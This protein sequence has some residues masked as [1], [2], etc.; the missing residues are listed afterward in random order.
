[1]LL[2]VRSAAADSWTDNWTVNGIPIRQFKKTSGRD[3]AVFSAGVLS[4]W[5]VHWLSHVSYLEMENLEWYQEGYREEVTTIMTDEQRRW[6]GRSG[7]VGQLIIGGVLKLTGMD[8]G[9]F[10]TGYHIGSFLHVS[11]YPMIHPLDRYRGG[12]MGSLREGGGNA[13]AEYAAYT[14]ASLFLLQPEYY[15]SDKD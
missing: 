7:F 1:M 11:T 13:A 4:S 8:K 10:G 6:L 15:P 5:T 9:Y 3:W 2:A 12:D 14:A